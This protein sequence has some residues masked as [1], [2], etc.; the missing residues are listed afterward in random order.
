MNTRIGLATFAA[1]TFAGCA[2]LRIDVD[3]YK[4]PLA[5]HEDI[6]VRQYAALA[7]AAR[8]VLASLRNRLEGKGNEKFGESLGPF[9]DDWAPAYKFT[10]ETARFVNG[11]L[12]FYHD[13]ADSVLGSEMESAN[14]SFQVVWHQNEVFGFSESK[15]RPLAE[16]LLKAYPR[17]T[18][19][20]VGIDEH[21]RL[22]GY[23]HARFLMSEDSTQVPS[24][25]SLEADRQ[26]KA[27]VAAL[28][29]VEPNKRKL[30]EELHCACRLME[31]SLSE[32]PAAQR[33][34]HVD[35]RDNIA[36]ASKN[37]GANEIYTE[38]SKSEVLAGYSSVL[39]GTI[40]QSYVSRVKEISEAFL[41]MRR[42]MRSLWK[43]M[44]EI[45]DHLGDADRSDQLQLAARF[46]AATSQPRAIA[47]YLTR[48]GAPPLTG[49]LG[50]VLERSVLRDSTG[51][52]VWELEPRT[53]DS[54]ENADSLDPYDSAGRAIRE[55]ATRFP[56]EMVKLLK[57]SDRAFIVATPGDL[58]GCTA[59]SGKDNLEVVPAIARQ[60]GFS[61]GPTLGR[62]F[63]QQLSRL[64]SN[65][66]LIA[67]GT[68]AG[69]ERARQIQGIDSLTTKFQETLLH[70]GN[71]LRNPRVISA[72][73]KLEET[74]IIWAERVLVAVNNR[75][76]LPPDQKDQRGAA[77]VAREAAVVQAVANTILIHADDT[78]RRDEH[79]QR[80]RD[81]G[82]VEAEAVRGAF[83]LTP[84]QALDNLLRNLHSEIE[85][86][87]R[88]VVPAKPVP[89]G[90]KTPLAIEEEKLQGK[91]GEREGAEE[92]A[93]SLAAAISV[94]FPPS[95]KPRA[96]PDPRGVKL[97]DSIDGQV[98]ALAKDKTKKGA[99]VIAAIKK[100]V[101]D[102]YQLE[103]ITDAGKR[104]AWGMNLDKTSK[105][106]K[107]N[108]DALATLPGD[109]ASTF[110]RNLNEKLLFDLASERA[111]VKTLMRQE[112]ELGRE[113]AR[114]KRGGQAAGRHA[115][116]SKA[117]EELDALRG[118]VLKKAND[119][120]VARQAGLL[121]LLADALQ[122]E[123]KKIE[124][125]T[126]DG[127]V[128]R[129]RGFDIAL[130]L[131]KETTPVRAPVMVQSRDAHPTQKDVV[132]DLL[133]MLR[134]Q[135]THALASN[136]TRRARGLEKAIESVL[137][138]RADLAYLRPASAY[139]RSVYAATSLQAKPDVDWVNMIARNTN[140]SLGAS[141]LTQF[142]KGYLETLGEID[143]QHWQNINTVNLAGGGN[144][145]YVLA[146]DDV[147]NWYVKA[148]SAD[149]SDIFRSAQGLALFGI[150]KGLDLNL[151][152]RAQLQR[153]LDS[154]DTPEESKA[155]IRG[156][157]DKVNAQPGTAGTDAL[158]RL[159]EGYR[160]DHAKRT[161]SE[162]EDLRKEIGR[163][164]EDIRSAWESGLSGASRDDVLNGLKSRHV[165][166]DA[167]GIAEIKSSNDA[168]TDI[169]AKEDATAA[170]QAGVMIRALESM[171][172]LRDRLES[173]IRG[174]NPLV[175]KYS[176]DLAQK[177]GALAEQRRKAQALPLDSDERKNLE[178]NIPGLETAANLA[179]SSHENAVENRTRGAK[180]VVDT[181]NPLIVRNAKR[182]IDTLRQLDTSLTL[183]GQAATGGP[184]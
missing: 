156:E 41:E 18:S 67:A 66:S 75:A 52:L 133:A 101:D 78:R 138:Q 94:V 19:N 43:A 50:S 100:A 89:Q 48:K 149:P 34:K 21:R 103:A 167:S 109:D 108:G 65:L 102:A 124:S 28:H 106:F 60:F 1:L 119:A 173:L 181:V 136:E 51:R 105:F 92:S 69:F 146:K 165:T 15:D 117:R 172:R 70:Y 71:D 58:T 64:A 7:V 44:L 116:Y 176:T 131:V 47:C 171:R 74:L 77:E 38:M 135:R 175:E 57:E 81:R 95:A 155:G 37:A 9:R 45:V 2:A 23:I 99:D 179:R 20:P 59:L 159:V 12:S 160:A 79:Q 31:Q 22:F 4:G 128:Q 26:K 140:R 113:V 157:L 164:G 55:A 46:L 184:R 169:L 49:G 36:C 93:E 182:R 114:L 27:S 126:A 178:K 88:D 148:Y 141:T 63:S 111:N 123:R 82:R 39:F 142:E 177:N 130:K 163:L 158:G 96:K 33:R 168:L 112:A 76:L 139:L 134:N 10:N 17:M 6:Q 121:A 3:V 161:R 152:R 137:E 13:T 35:G 84:A 72:R 30:A 125:S 8:P 73:K 62:N 132:D 110:F 162:A 144:I 183:V 86:I 91:K 61:R 56:K 115:D 118:S 90:G 40:D 145:N 53:A 80:L 129:R 25:C 97:I 120:G 174:D 42:A 151:L 16:R 122:A 180:S 166:E 107:T 68:V 127:D 87:S 98:K 14:R 11:A 85:R 83:D 143:K 32:L 24:A 29:N 54:S 104:S 5:N 150:G 170:E 147:G 154:R 153:Q